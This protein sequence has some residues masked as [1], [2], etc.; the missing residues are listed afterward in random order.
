MLDLQSETLVLHPRQFQRVHGAEESGMAMLMWL[1]RTQCRLDPC[2]RVL[3]VS[4]SEWRV[5]RDR[6]AFSMPA[7]CGAFS[8]IEAGV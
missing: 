3:A 6:G 2:P 8:V 4:P 7:P 1:I 5:W